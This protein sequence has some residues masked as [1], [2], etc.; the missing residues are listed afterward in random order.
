MADLMDIIKNW[1]EDSKI[2]DTDLGRESLKIPTLHCKYYEMYMKERMIL[3]K[4]KR[5]LNGLEHLYTQYYSGQLGRDELKE[6][7]LEQWDIKVLKGDIPRY[8]E[9]TPPIIKIK[10]A[11]GIQSEKIDFIK[12]IL[13]QIQTRS[14]MI[15][16]CIEWKKF[17]AGF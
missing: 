12:S 8:L 7:G 2:D 11:M 16:D 14:F 15:R 1:R 9:T 3:E 5:E 13:Q 17:S 10:D 4:L 6:H